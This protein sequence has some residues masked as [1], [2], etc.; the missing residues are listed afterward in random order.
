M[1]GYVVYPTYETIDGKTS[2]KLFGRLENG[3]SF[4]TVNK[5]RPYLY[6]RKKNEKKIDKFPEPTEI[7]ETKFVNFEGE[8]LVKLFFKTKSE[9][10]E[11]FKVN[12]KKIETYEADIRPQSRFFIDNDILGGVNI[13]GEYES[14]EKIDR[15][16][17]EP[18]IKSANFLPD[19]KVI[20]IDL[21]SG[22][23]GN[24]FCI[25]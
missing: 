4:A 19:L 12:H 24:L 5:F 21:E 13:E 23:K 10:D 7:E 25:G 18:D 20:S 8:H 17:M 2:I 9:L 15:V 14:A 22:K 3:Q 11:F 6:I 1:K 16:Y